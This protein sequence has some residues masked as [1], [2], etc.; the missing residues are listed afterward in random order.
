M[1]CMR[2]AVWQVV[3]ER[4]AKSVPRTET[5]SVPRTVPVGTSSIEKKACS[6]SSPSPSSL[7]V[8]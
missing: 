6:S 3:H 1:N 7:L 5:P 8:A 2:Q 4:S